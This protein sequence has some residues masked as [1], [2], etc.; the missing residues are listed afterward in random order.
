MVLTLDT[1]RGARSPSPWPLSLAPRRATLEDATTRRLLFS[2]VTSHRHPTL[3][4][5]PTSL[6]LR[7]SR[8]ALLPPFPPA[9]SR[10]TGGPFFPP[11]GRTPALFEYSCN[12]LTATTALCSGIIEYMPCVDTWALT[13]RLPCRRYCPLEE[14]SSTDRPMV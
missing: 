12:L 3:S 1:E 6:T 13:K 2:L 11:P 5:W 9:V 14:D 8:A 10:D 4:T 7:R